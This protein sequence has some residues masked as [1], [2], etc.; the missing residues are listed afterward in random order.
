MIVLRMAISGTANR[1]PMIPKS[2]L[3]AATA[4]KTA[5]GCSE[6]ALPITR[7]CRMLDS[8]CCTARTTSSMARAIPGLTATSATRTATAPVSTAPTMGMNEA[9][10]TRTPIGSARGT[11]SRNA[12][13]PMPTASTKATKTWIR[14][15][16][17]REIQPLRP[18]PLTA[19]RAR[20]G[21]SFTRKSQMLSP[22]M[23]KNSST[24]SAMTVPVT[25]LLAVEPN[26]MAPERIASE[27]ACRVLPSSENHW[28]MVSVEM[29]RRLSSS[30]P[31][32]CW[33]PATTLLESCA[34]PTMIC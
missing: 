13:R 31:M 26:L 22:S 28:L 5:T 12:P 18:A 10:N 24:N 15:Y 27:L 32:S 14:T 34:K 17:A 21:K 29:F 4:R 19:G 9:R 16:C 3:P 2:T 23:R 1:A 6:T 7:G 33:K 25:M 20:R 8:I 30:M 11:C